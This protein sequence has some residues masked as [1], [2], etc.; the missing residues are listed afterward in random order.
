MAYVN[1]FTITDVPVTC[2]GNASHDW[3]SADFKIVAIANSTNTAY[4]VQIYARIDANGWMQWDGTCTLRVKCNGRTGSA[5]MKLT[6]Y[7]GSEGALTEWDGP[8]TFAFGDAEAVSLNFEY[9]T[10]DLTTTIGTNGLP[11]IY[12]VTDDKNMT[13]FTKTNYTISVGDGGLE[14]L[15]QP[16]VLTTL[17]NVAPYNS[18]SAVSEYTDRISLSWTSD[19]VI[20][21]SYYRIN[22]GSWQSVGT[23]GTRLILQQLTAGTSYKIDLYSV[24]GAGNSNTLSTTIRTRHLQP[25]IVMTFDSKSIDTLTYSWTSDKSLASGQYRIGI[26]GE[27]MN[28]NTSGTSGKFTINNL[29]PNTKYTIFFRGTATNDYDSLVSEIVYQTTTTY[30]FATLINATNLILGENHLLTVD[31]LSNRTAKVTVRVEGNSRVAE[32]VF[33]VVNGDNTIVYNQTQLDNIYRCFTNTNFINIKFTV[34]TTG[35]WKTYTHEKTYTLYLTGI[36]KTAHLNVNGNKRAEAWLGI[37]DLP[38]RAIFWVGDENN[39]PRR[40]I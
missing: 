17:S 6:M 1:T 7:N 20:T 39:K 28:A 23:S 4:T 21:N 32:S 30:N 15:L 22:N 29:E 5:N 26:N 2:T 19:K 12:H 9:I 3:I 24:N 36:V 27:W 13:A 34:S 25:V 10:I 31:H 38:R 35:G 33:D 8:V 14:P 40:C 16:P 11:G 18:N 37:N